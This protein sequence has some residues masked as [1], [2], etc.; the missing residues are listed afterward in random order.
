MDF[1]SQKIIR[2]VTPVL[3][4]ALLF[5]CKKD[6]LYINLPAFGP[7]QI[8]YALTTQNRLVTYNAQD[9]RTSAANVSI[10]GLAASETLISIDFRPATGELYGIS[11]LNKLYIIDIATGT[12]KAVAATAFV[13]SLNGT[14]VSMDFNPA[15]DRIR[16]VSNNGQNLRLNPETGQLEG[17]DNNIAN[18]AIAGIAYSNNYAGSMTPTLYDLDVTAKKIYKQEPQN[19]GTLILAGNLTQ[20][21]GSGVSFDISPNNTALAVGKIADSTKLY[22][23]DLTSGKTSLAGK[24]V[25]GTG[26]RSIAIP[27]YPV[28]YAVDNDR[29]LLIFN[30]MPA[31]TTFYT[32]AIT[33]IQTGE[34]ILGMDIRPA[35]GQLYALGSTNR[36]YLINMATGAATLVGNGPLNVALSGSNFGVDFN[37]VTDVLHVISNIGQHLTFNLTTNSASSE[38]AIPVSN[39][40]TAIA[41]NNNFR[42]ASATTLYAIDQATNKLF[43]QN[44]ATSV[45]TAVGDLK[46]EISAMNGFDI[47]YTAQD[48]AYAIF[49]VAGKTNLYS[50][51]LTTG[52]ATLKSE[53]PK[54]VT[55]FAL[56]L[57]I[58]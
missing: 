33:G 18:A 17:T 13:T 14:A 40:I 38:T 37:P 8:F 36:L 43:T 49:T 46:I 15:D 7:N 34:N 53:L 12:T 21:I 41:Y 47:A 26:I 2:L 52:L 48:F 57:R 23:I 1:I 32:R 44:Q 56:G 54:P 24:F 29:N 25:Q 51:S 22:A 5:G 9:V 39:N 11:N 42:N 45:L 50:L 30:P 3:L 28:A 58:N 16:I 4:L 20:D 19:S 35:T 27:T 10:S 55:A 31:Q 6:E